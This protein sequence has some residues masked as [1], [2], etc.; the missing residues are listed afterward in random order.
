MVNLALDVVA[1]AKMGLDPSLAN[2]VNTIPFKN[3]NTDQYDLAFI[4]GYR[5]KELVAMKYGYD[6]PDRVVVEV[7]Y[8]TDHFIPIKKDRDNEVE[9]YEF[10]IKNAFDRGEIVGGFYYHAFDDEPWKNKVVMLSMADIEKR[11]PKYASAEFWGGE[12]T[13]WKDGKPSG[14]EKVEGWFYEMVYKT[15]Y[16]AAYGSITIDAHKIDDA[17]Q[18]MLQSE[19][20]FNFEHDDQAFKGHQNKIGNANQKELD[21]SEAEEVNDNTPFPDK[22]DEPE[23]AKNPEPEPVKKTTMF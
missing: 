21:I 19:R 8:S 3:N 2:H 12:K 22:Q 18:R 5:G 16:R 11:K 20:E 9:T 6:V 23:P 17:M 4:V 1:H 10:K 7:V 13:A 14:T 15:I